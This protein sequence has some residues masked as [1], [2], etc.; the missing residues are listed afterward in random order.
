[1]TSGDK[2]GEEEEDDPCARKKKKVRGK[3]E[4]KKKG[5]GEAQGLRRKE[6]GRSHKSLDGIGSRLINKRERRS[7]R[8]RGKQKGRERK[9]SE[10]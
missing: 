10:G 6:E 3:G 1:V 9:H 7:A 5:T 8:R 4:E 2:R